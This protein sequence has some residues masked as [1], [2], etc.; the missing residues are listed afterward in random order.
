[1]FS[2]HPNGAFVA[3]ADGHVRFVSRSVDD[4]VIAAICT[5][6]GGEPIGDF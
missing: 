4:A 6:N 5:R 1:V 3:F 2:L